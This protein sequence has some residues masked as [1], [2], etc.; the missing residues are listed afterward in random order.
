VLKPTANQ[1]QATASQILNGLGHGFNGH[2][3]AVG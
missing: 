1:I 2:G 3:L